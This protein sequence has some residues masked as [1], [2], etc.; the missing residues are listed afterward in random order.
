MSV[1]GLEEV[2]NRDHIKPKRPSRSWGQGFSVSQ[3]EGRDGVET[4]QMI[5]ASIKG[6]I[7]QSLSFPASPSTL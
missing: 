1:I 2:R 3:R 7:G 5:G 6:D 4:K